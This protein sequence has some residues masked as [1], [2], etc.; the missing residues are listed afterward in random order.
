MT[1]KKDLNKKGN[2]DIIILFDV[3]ALYLTSLVEVCAYINQSKTN[4]T[5]VLPK[6]A[7]ATPK[8]FIAHLQDL[9]CFK[10]LSSAL[11]I[12]THGSTQLTSFANQSNFL[13]NFCSPPKFWKLHQSVFQ[14]CR[15]L[16]RLCALMSETLRLFLIDLGVLG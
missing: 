12:S 16:A 5:C 9:K 3:L 14:G 4:R 8:Y 7:L 11:L 15:V 10:H 6:Y 13:N 1:S 2:N